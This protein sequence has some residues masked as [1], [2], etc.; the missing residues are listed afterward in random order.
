[1]VIYCLLSAGASAAVCVVYFRGVE[2]PRRLRSHG[3]ERVGVLGG[4]ERGRLSGYGYGVAA[5]NGVGGGWG[6]TGQGKVD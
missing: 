3:R 6:Y 5:S 1:M 4:G 2:L